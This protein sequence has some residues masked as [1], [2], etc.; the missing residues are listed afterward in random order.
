VPDHR[1]KLIDVD[2]GTGDLQSAFGLRFRQ[3]VDYHSS[4]IF[5]FVRS[6]AAGGIGQIQLQLGFLPG[7]MTGDE[8][9]DDQQ[10]HDVDHGRHVEP[11]ASSS[12]V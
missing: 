7:K 10:E 5:I 1:L 8:E 4:Y 6:I 12:E 2:D 3:H 11:D 9:K